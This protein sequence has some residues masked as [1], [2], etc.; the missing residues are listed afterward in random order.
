MTKNTYLTLKVQQ[1]FVIIWSGFPEI[2]DDLDGYNLRD[3]EAG[4]TTSE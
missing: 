4:P 1:L 2:S 3:Q